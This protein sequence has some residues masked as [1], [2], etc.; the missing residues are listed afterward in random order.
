MECPITDLRVMDDPTGC[1][2]SEHFFAQLE[3]I[4]KLR[5][6]PIRPHS[7]VPGESEEGESGTG[8]CMHTMVQPTWFPLL[9]NLDCDTP[10]I[11]RFR[12]DLLVSSSDVPHP[13]IIN[14]SLILS[15]WKLSG[16]GSLVK[17]FRKAWSTY[18]WKV[19][20]NPRQLLISQHGGPGVFGTIDGVRI[21]CLAL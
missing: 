4:Q 19:T 20:E 3:Q 13:L 11:F 15:A 2:C 6:S 16:D 10:R 8:T 17:T 14:N 7:Q 1:V 5:L 18:C 9:L 12:P 21:P